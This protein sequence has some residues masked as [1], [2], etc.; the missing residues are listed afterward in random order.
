MWGDRQNGVLRQN[1]TI[2]PN[3]SQK[4]SLSPQKVVD[5][6]TN[7]CYNNIEIWG[8][9]SV[10]RAFEWHSKGQR[11]ETAYLHQKI[12]ITF[13]TEIFLFILLPLHLEGL[14]CD[15]HLA[16]H[17][18]LQGYQAV[19]QMLVIGFLE[20]QLCFEESLSLQPTQS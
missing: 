2:L 3:F 9:S 5:N 14:H 4:N 15:T 16:H 17:Q 11:F 10:G 8:Y 12:S 18:G 19:S 13:V 20:G 6:V 7:L 1:R